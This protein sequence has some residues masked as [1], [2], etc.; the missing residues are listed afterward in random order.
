MGLRT[1][2][3]AASPSPTSTTGSRP[4]SCGEGDALADRVDRPARHADRDDVAEPLHLRPVAQPLDQQRPQGDP[5][6]DAVLVAGEPRVVGQLGQAEHLD[7]LAELPVVAR[8]HDE[9]AVG[10]G[11][12]LVREQAGVAVA[13]PARHDAAGDVRAALVDQAG[14][15]RGQQVHLDVLPDAGLAPH[16]Q[17]RQH[18]DRGVQPGHHVEDRDAGAVGLAVGGAGQAHQAGDG[19]H[20]QV[21]AGQRRP[22][23]TA[24]EAADRGVDDA[25]GWWRR[26][27]RSRARSGPAR[28]AG[29]SRPAR[30]P[31]G[32]ARCATA[33]SAGSAR[34]SAIDRLLRLM[35][36]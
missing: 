21:V 5:V 8:G 11:Q 29:S 36:R 30:R 27:C 10:A 22:A 34:S 7:Q 1:E 26:R 9:V 16:V 25:P 17:R 35:L 28:P 2:G 31:G 6:H 23:R 24:A 13:H 19:L 3:T 18:A 32:P 12:R 14:Q 20:D 4:T 15:R 33:R